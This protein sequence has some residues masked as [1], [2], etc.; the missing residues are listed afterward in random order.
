MCGYLCWEGNV[1]GVGWEERTC[2]HTQR[3]ASPIDG[4]SAILL[5]YG[6]IMYGCERWTIK[7]AEQWRMEA[8]KLVLEKILESPLDGKEIKPV[9]PKGNQPRILI[10]RTCA[11]API[12][13]P[14]DTNSR[15]IGEDPNSRKDW[16]QEKGTTEDELSG[17]HH[18]LN[19]HESEQTP[20]DGEGQGNLAM[21]SPW[22][23]K[24]SD[25]TERLNNYILK[26]EFHERRNTIV[27]LGKRNTFD[28]IAPIL[29][30]SQV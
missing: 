16:G 10:G 15:L 4:I 5:M 18:Q 17:W 19:G 7:K 30:V 28:N 14:P 24:E 8:F 29:L 12:L 2:V 3:D 23:R 26:Q 21:R 25:M 6:S 11:E 13:W 1:V 20:G 9:N 27:K 22:G